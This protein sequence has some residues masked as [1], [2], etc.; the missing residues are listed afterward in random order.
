MDRR[1]WT[2]SPS[3]RDDTL[4][5]LLAE[6]RGLQSAV[7]AR[8]GLVAANSG[9]DELG[10]LGGKAIRLAEGARGYRGDVF[11]ADSD[12]VAR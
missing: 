12:D 10:R 3:C 11:I 2:R 6:D 7:M 5:G 9:N 1:I 4:R 8:Q